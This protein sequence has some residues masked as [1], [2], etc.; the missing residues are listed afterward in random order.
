ME[1]SYVEQV[2]INKP[3]KIDGLHPKAKLVVLVLYI[4]CTFIISSVKVTSMD[5][6][7]YLIVW[8]VV[9][10]ILFAATGHFWKCIKGCKLV[11]S[12]FA[13]IFIVQSLIMNG[14]KE[15]FRLG[16]VTVE[17]AG[18]QKACSL[19]FMV[20]D[21]A[22]IFVWF[23]QTTSHKEI[24]AALNESGVN[25][26]VSYVFV[27]TLK[28]ID[29]MSKNSKTI[30]SAQQARG[31]ETEGN[32]LVRAKAFVPSLVPLILT[33]VTGAEERVMTLEARGFSVKGERT[34][35]YKLKKSG[36][37]VPFMLFWAVVTLAVAAW[38][39]FR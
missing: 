17:Q 1:K 7:L 35:V 16:F 23:F 38:R 39:I 28:M 25:D 24:A 13:I 10:L 2:Q 22:G 34:S 9:L 26:K 18:L 4:I 8:F 31:I 33:A 21:V 36:I 14:G 6:P 32:L 37:E 5:L 19:G 30:M 3:N 27:S 15:L 11:F 29:E 12:I 20:L